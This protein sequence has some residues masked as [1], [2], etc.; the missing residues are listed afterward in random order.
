MVRGDPEDA[1][2]T[3]RG[4]ESDQ[5]CGLAPVSAVRPSRRLDC[6]R[7][8][9][10]GRLEDLLVRLL[11][12]RFA[13]WPMFT[14]EI[15]NPAMTTSVDCCFRRHSADLAGCKGSDHFHRPQSALPLGRSACR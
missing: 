15:T 3:T 7:E 6:E 8:G 14:A 4:A 2:N 11:R 13:Q 5:A 9:L 12:R 10:L 1:E